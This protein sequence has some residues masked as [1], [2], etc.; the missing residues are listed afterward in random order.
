MNFEEIG[1]V[2]ASKGHEV[3]RGRSRDGDNK[4]YPYRSDRYYCENGRWF[5]TTREAMSNGPFASR[6]Q[7]ERDFEVAMRFNFKSDTAA[8]L[9]FTVAWS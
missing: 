5:Y 2:E 9:S 6:A 8:S 4:V 7:A 1:V 3:S